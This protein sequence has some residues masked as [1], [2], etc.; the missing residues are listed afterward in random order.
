MTTL[1]ERAMEAV[2]MRGTLPDGYQGHRRAVSF[3]LV[4]GL[5]L[6]VYT[7]GCFHN[8]IKAATVEDA[9]EKILRGYG[10]RL[11]LA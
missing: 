7:G 10:D 11:S 9:R 2:F 3:A 6:V 8:G 5:V 4:E 1:Y